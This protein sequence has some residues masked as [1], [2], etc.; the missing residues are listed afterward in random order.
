[1]AISININI[2]IDEMLYNFQLHFLCNA[3]EQ[4]QGVSHSRRFLPSAC[5]SFSLHPDVVVLRL[6]SSV[7]HCCS[8]LLHTNVEPCKASNY[9]QQTLSHHVINVT[10]S[11]PEKISSV[12]VLLSPLPC[13]ITAV[14]R[15]DT[16]QLC[17]A[18]SGVCI[19]S[20]RRKSKN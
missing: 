6:R 10:V 2:N 1:M 12:R 5:W 4:R 14:L 8:V 7:A 18:F 19:R 11:M 13:C 15:R 16:T 3:N 17:P 9:K 20:L